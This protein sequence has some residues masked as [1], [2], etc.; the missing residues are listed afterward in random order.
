MSP[1]IYAGQFLCGPQWNLRVSMVKLRQEN[2]HHRGRR[3]RTEHHGEIPDALTSLLNGIA[4]VKVVPSPGFDSISSLP[5]RPWARAFMLA[6]P[7]PLPWAFTSNPLP[8]SL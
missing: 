7:C 6:R 4:S 2:A 8:L 3:D 5:P 1:H